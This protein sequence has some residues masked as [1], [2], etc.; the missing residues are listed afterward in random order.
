M[1]NENNMRPEH[2]TE[3]LISQIAQGLE[4]QYLFF[5]GHQPRKDGSIGKTCFS[6]WFEAP[7]RLNGIHYA[8]AEHYMMAEKA[9]LFDDDATLAKILA[10]PTPAHAKKLGREVA[11]F[12]NARWEARGFDAVVEGNVAKFTQNPAMGEFLRT[13][14][15][16]VLVEASPVD[17]VWGIGLAGDDPRAL[18]PAQWQGTNLLG[19]A[20]MRVREVIREARP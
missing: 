6:Q 8:T 7:F 15:H 10:A 1:T 11:G 17:R 20:L 19:F 13:T 9:R 16:R 18:Q 14:G 2:H 12:D 4:P 5:W 3:Q